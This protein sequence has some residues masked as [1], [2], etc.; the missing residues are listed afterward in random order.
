MFTQPFLPRELGR[1][2][3]V[4]IDFDIDSDIDHLL[5]RDAIV[6]R[7]ANSEALSDRDRESRPV[8]AHARGGHRESALDR[9]DFRRFIVAQL[10][11]NAIDFAEL[12]LVAAEELFVE[13]IAH[14]LQFEPPII[15]SGIVTSAMIDVSTIVTTTTVL[16]IHP[17]VCSPTNFSS[18]IRMRNGTMTSARIAAVNAIA[19]IVS[20]SGSMPIPIT[21]APINRLTVD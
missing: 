1:F 12:L 16:P 20:I 14:E 11:H 4:D 6:R 10:D 19:Q 13:N 2:I 9:R 3:G 7:L 21:S 15:C 17:F 18:F 5:P 8:F